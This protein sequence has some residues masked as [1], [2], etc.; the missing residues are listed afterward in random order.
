MADERSDEEKISNILLRDDRYKR[1]AYRFVQEALDFTMRKR[2]KRGHVSGRELALGVR[3]L[4]KERFG[5]MARTVLNQWG[6]KA[7]ADVGEL[8]FTMIEEELMVKQETDTRTDFENVFDFEKA[9]DDDFEINI[10]R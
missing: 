2:G 7:S 10:E 8:V 5:L 6:I 1:E 9:F 4:A 3:D